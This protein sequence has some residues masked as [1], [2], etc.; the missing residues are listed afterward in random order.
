MLNLIVKAPVAERANLAHSQI[1][2]R[3]FGSIKRM[4][5]LGKMFYAEKRRL[6]HGEWLPWIRDNLTFS[7]QTAERYIRIYLCRE[8]VLAAKPDTLAEAL[9]AI[10]DK[11]KKGKTRHTK[12]PSIAD[13][14]LAERRTVGLVKLAG[15]AFVNLT[16]PEA[17]LADITDKIPANID[18]CASAHNSG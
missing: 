3:D 10:A 7:A 11:G 17:D 1:G 8:K 16:L 15:K 14:K 13:I 2:K 6:R 12:N 4:I 5:A 9:E 18:R